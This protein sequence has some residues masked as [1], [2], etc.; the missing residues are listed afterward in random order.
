MHDKNVPEWYI[1]SLRKIR[2]MFPKAHS[3]AYVMNAV[4]MAWYKIY[5]PTEFYAAYLSC[6]Y[7]GDEPM[8]EEDE[9]RF[10]EIVDECS[11]RGIQLLKP[12]EEKSHRVN[13][14][15]EQGNIRMPYAK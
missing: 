7:P 9:P 2:Y 15:P 11:R 5:Y 13:Y 6:S 1:Q 8:C 14:L 4:R 3:V 12:D 10:S